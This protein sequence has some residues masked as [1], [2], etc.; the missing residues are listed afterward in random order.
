MARKKVQLQKGLSL[1]NFKKTTTKKGNVLM[2]YSLGYGQTA[3]FVLL[4]AI[5]RAATD[6]SYSSHGAVPLRGE[7]LRRQAV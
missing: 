3:L 7:K 6:L 5:T 4:T 1:A 2:C